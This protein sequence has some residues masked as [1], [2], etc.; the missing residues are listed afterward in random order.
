[1]SGPRRFGLEFRAGAAFSEEGWRFATGIGARYSLRSDTAIVWNPIVGAHLVYLPTSGDRVSHI[2]ATIAE[3]G[4]RIQQPLEG[5]Y[6]D[7]RAGAYVGLEA[8]GPR[9]PSTES[10]SAVAGFTPAAGLGYRSERLSV[11]AEARGF[12]G[13][14]PDQFLI[15]GAGAW[16]W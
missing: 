5:F 15:L 16:H 11:G 8:P 7:V 13:A 3:L 1:V 9:A 10:T 6:F 2:A 4:L 14:G 12:V